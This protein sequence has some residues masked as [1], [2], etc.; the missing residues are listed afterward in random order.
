M[1]L[2]I[3][4]GDRLSFL[5]PWTLILE[6]LLLSIVLALAWAGGW[7]GGRLLGLRLIDGAGQLPAFWRLFLRALPT[8]AGVWLVAVALFY[9]YVAT[10]APHAEPSAESLRFVAREWLYALPFLANY[11]PLAL[12]QP[13]TVVD[14]LLDVKVV[15]NR[16]Q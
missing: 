1:V 6:W 9:T 10:A 11:L 7:S 4:T 14:R 13:S 3:V 5:Y 8:T 2:I 12:G 16:D 15:K